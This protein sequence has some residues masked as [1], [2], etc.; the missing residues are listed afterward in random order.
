MSDLL[1]VEVYDCLDC[2][3]NTFFKNEYYMIH[4]EIWDS[5]ATD[6]MLCVECLEKRLGR[7]LTP[8]DFKLYPI[9]FGVFPQSEILRSRVYGDD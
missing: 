7:L 3:D 9:N 4:D 1:D 6:G 5:V 2:G 8:E